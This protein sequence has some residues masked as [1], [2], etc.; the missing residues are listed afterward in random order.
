LKWSSK[1]L[2]IVKTLRRGWTVTIQYQDFNSP[3]FVDEQF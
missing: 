3:M 1:T 2:D